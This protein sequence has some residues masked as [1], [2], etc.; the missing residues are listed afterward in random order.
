MRLTL[1]R[2]KVGD[3]DGTAVAEQHHQDGQ[4]DSRLSRRHRQNEKDEDL[5]G[6]IAENPEKAMKLKF[7]ASS[8]NSIDISRIMTFF[9]FRKNAGHAETKEDRPS[10]R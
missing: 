9:R 10:T 1:Q 3:V 4:T 7:T 6:G 8:I 5:A 2:I